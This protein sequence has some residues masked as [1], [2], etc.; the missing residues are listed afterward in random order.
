MEKSREEDDAAAARDESIME[1]QRLSNVVVV[2][3][4]MVLG[5]AASLMDDGLCNIYVMSK[6]RGRIDLAVSAM[7]IAKLANS[8]LGMF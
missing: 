4:M 3:M 1:E 6:I 5:N 8:D 2:M 7:V